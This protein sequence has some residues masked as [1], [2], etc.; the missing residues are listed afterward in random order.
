MKGYVSYPTNPNPYSSPQPQRATSLLFSW[1]KMWKDGG[2]EPHAH[3]R[4][5]KRFCPNATNR[6][7]DLYGM[8]RLSAQKLII[9]A[10]QLQTA[11]NPMRQF[12]HFLYFFIYLFT[13]FFLGQ[14]IFYFS[15][16]FLYMKI[17]SANCEKHKSS[18]SDYNKLIIIN[19]WLY[20]VNNHPT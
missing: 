6:I 7:P 16:L 20:Y 11:L 9:H 10:V 12:V 15:S 14:I 4:T 1:I 18:K 19:S 3:T 5:H 13:F 2:N 8:C 17:R